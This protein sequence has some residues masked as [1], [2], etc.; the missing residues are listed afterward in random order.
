MEVS[1]CA[2]MLVWKAVIETSG[3]ARLGLH[4]QENAGRSQSATVHPWKST[5]IGRNN[6]VV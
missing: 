6:L 3:A 5:Q 1:W 2:S 4:A